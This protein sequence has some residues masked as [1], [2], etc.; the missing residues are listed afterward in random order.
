LGSSAKAFA[1]DRAAHKISA[2]L[3]T[4]ALVNLG[5][6][7]AIAGPPP[8]GGWRVALALSSSAVTDEA[9]VTVTVHT[10]GLASSG[11]TARVWKQGDRALHHIVDPRTGDVTDDY[12][13]LVTVAAERCLMA[14]AVSTAAIVAGNKAEQVVENF[15]L[16]ARLVRRD[17][18]VFVF[19]GWPEDPH[20][21]HQPADR[22]R[23]NAN[24]Q[25]L[26]CNS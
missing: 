25:R 11:T 24:A 18:H 21:A 17:G 22:H 5:G 8:E 2:E 4:G 12:W 26:Y 6:D 3:G 13:A 16:P 15:G 1:A 20:A 19:N 10:G 14:N 9:Q 23:S 7:I